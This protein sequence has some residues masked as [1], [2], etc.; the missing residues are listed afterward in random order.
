MGRGTM[1]NIRPAAICGFLLL[2][3]VA[4][5]PSRMPGQGLF[6]SIRGVITDAG[7]AVVQ[8]ATVKLTN[9]NTNVVTVLTTNS[10]GEYS[11]TS[12]NPGIYDIQAEAPGFKAAIAKGITLQVNASPK[13]DLTLQVGQSTQTV[14]VTAE[15]DILQTQ[16]T[17]LGQSVNQVQLD[18]LPLFSSSGRNIFNLIPLAA[19]VSE[20]IGAQAGNNNN[21]RINGDRPRD[22]DYIL[23]GT[24]ITDPFFGGQSLSPSPESIQEFRVDTNSL[25]AAYGKSGGGIV[26]ATTKTGTNRFHGSAYEYYRGQFLDARN[27]FEEPSQPQ[28]PYHYS[29]FGGSIGGPIVRNK[30]FFFTDYQGIRTGGDT[31]VSGV[32]VPDAAFRS[33]NLA[34]LCSAGFNSSGTCLDPN[35]QVYYPGTSNPVPFNRIRNIN[36]IS[37]K[38]LALYPTSTASAGIPGTNVLTQRSPFTAP[39]NRVNPRIDYNLSAR[40]RLFGAFHYEAGPSTYYD[41]VL[42]PAGQQNNSFHDYATT[43][44]WTHT[45]SPTT[46]NEFRFG[47]MDNTGNR[48]QYGQGFTSPADYGLQGFPNCLASVPGNAGG[49]KCG[50]PGVSINGFTDLA[51]GQVN[52]EPDATLQ[53]TDSVAKLVGRHSL[54]FGAE[55]RRYYINNYQPNANTGSFGFDGSNTAIYASDGTPIG[56]NPFADFL[57]GTLAP[58]STA[59]VENVMTQTR[60]N[61]YAAFIQDDFKFTRKLTINLG[62]RYQWDD[63][64]YEL[65]NGM[66]FFNP[67]EAQWI[68]FGV[69]G[70]PRTSFDA[71]KK[72]FGPRVGV[73]W[74]PIPGFVVR[75]GYGIMFPGAVGHGRAGDGQPGPNLDANTT[76]PAG[77]NW[78][79]LP[80]IYNPPP[81]HIT[82]P[83]PIDANGNLSFSVWAPRS[84]PPTYNQLWNLTLE[85]QLG[86]KSVI[87]VAY[88]GDHGTHLPINYG[89]NICQQT[90]ESTA[91]YGYNATT[92]PYCPKAA[93][94]I[95]PSGSLYDLIV[96]PGWWGL[97]SSSYNAFTVRYDHRFS[98]GFS[99]LANFTWSKLIDDSSSDWSGFWDLDVLGQDFYNRKADRSVSAGDVPVRFTVA[100]IVELPFGKG[101]TWLQSGVPSYIAGGW[102]VSAIYTVS[103]GYP[104]GIL[105]NSYGYCNAA[106][107]LSDRP[108]L[109]GNP[110]PPGFH[111]T[112]A[113][114]FDTNA[115]DFSGTCPVAGLVDLT[116]PGD[117]NKAFGNSPRYY[118]NIR[119]PGVN[120]LDF[121]LQKDFGLPLGEQT[122]LKFQMDAFNVLNHPQFAPPNNDPTGTNFGGITSTSTNNRVLQLGV[123]LYF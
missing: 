30:L 80:P 85:K 52:Y 77:T 97:S 59:E 16:Q 110:L 4:L 122:R 103:D 92:S 44:G 65:H 95:P 113:H 91:K 36:P 27:Y 84:Q 17:N 51:G 118:S 37:Q 14:E 33:G 11:A 90:P 49:T 123:H 35:G 68:Q 54:T 50:T 19:G 56:G 98:H 112:I 120:N 105:D 81:S 75:A 48:A 121:S 53:F 73:A 22:Q 15:A 100:P 115:M 25:S 70:E 18:E 99:V 69:N 67:Y 34:A 87:Q 57:F 29:E 3:L 78:S 24:T 7:G 109:I 66:A 39:L 104:F 62:M 20:Q 117:P 32:L 94:A 28:N 72:N 83:I 76:F 21:L 114:W 89:Y 31:V 9:V 13:V 102:R 79:A 74:N 23:D 71:W 108:M 96:N 60:A 6:G 107:V 45:F 42:G 46:L 10:A 86:S 63:S 61:T 5:F 106:H 1:R 41:I 38:I 101:K 55:F 82:A 43:V 47:Y 12:L 26:F 40:D 2:S 58:G 64:F 116:G 88:V 8:G 111:Q 119:N 93:A